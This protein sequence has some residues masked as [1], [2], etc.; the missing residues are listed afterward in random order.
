MVTCPNCSLLLVDG[1]TYWKRL[2]NSSTPARRSFSSGRDTRTTR[3]SAP[4]RSSNKRI[5]PVR[6]WRQSL[7]RT[8]PMTKSPSGFRIATYVQELVWDLRNL[9]FFIV[10]GLLGWCSSLWALRRSEFVRQLI[11]KSPP[12]LLKG[13]LV[14]QSLPYVFNARE[15]LPMIS[16]LKMGSFSTNGVYL[17]RKCRLSVCNETVTIRCNHS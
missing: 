7:T 10:T 13:S 4:A 17:W 11:P 14:L 5:K 1:I 12:Y 9:M 6:C 15:L 2:P 8:S 3:S 16:F